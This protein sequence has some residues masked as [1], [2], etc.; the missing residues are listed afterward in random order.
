MAR[1]TATLRLPVDA[2]L[3]GSHG[4]SAAV[5]QAL[6]ASGLDLEQATRLQL[7]ASATAG[8]PW[9]LGFR[10]VISWT[11]AMASAQAIELGVEILSREP[12][13]TGGPSTRAA[14]DQVLTALEQHLPGLHVLQSST[15]T[16]AAAIGAD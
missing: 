8:G 9:P 15:A 4:V 7:A 10:L 11:A 12:M 3:A 16:A 5:S 2:C 13:A 14:L 1:Y 6:M